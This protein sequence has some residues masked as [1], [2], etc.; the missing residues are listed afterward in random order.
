MKTKAGLDPAPLS[1]TY[2]RD[3]ARLHRFL[4]HPRAR[5]R[6]GHRAGASRLRYLRPALVGA[7]AR[8]V[9]RHHRRCPSRLPSR[10]RRLHLDCQLSGLRPGLSRAHPR[11]QRGRPPRRA[12]PA[13]VRRNCRAGPRA[14]CP[15]ESPPYLDRRFTRS[16]WRRAP[17]RSRISRS[18]CHRL[19]RSG[20]L[21]CRTSRHPG[22][23]QRRSH[24]T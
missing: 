4:L 10:R 20:R 19:R 3:T 8:P 6:H 18:L 16:L 11:L 1:S 14:V 13:P 17:Q 22:R 23:H 7:R 24:R 15:G 12:C 2:S 21:P 5:W 9:P